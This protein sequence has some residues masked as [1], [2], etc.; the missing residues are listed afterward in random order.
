MKRA[1]GRRLAVSALSI[2]VA[3][4]FA[5]AAWAAGFTLVGSPNPGAANSIG[6]LVA[7]APADVWAIGTASSPSY[8]GCH[9]RTLTARWDGAGFAEVPSAATPICASVNGASGTAATD[10]WAVGS[11]NDG[12]DTSIRHWNGT[13]WSIVAGATLTPP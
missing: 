4:A 12:R 3:G 8:A 6:A 2:G 11:A 9:S 1:G 10:I 5:A 13:A 7:F